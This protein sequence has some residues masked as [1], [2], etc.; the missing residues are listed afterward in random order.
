MGRGD[1]EE[2][3]G[4]RRSRWLGLP[5]QDGEEVV[6]LASPSKSANL[7]KYLYTLGLYGFWRRRDRAVVTDRRVLIGRGIFSRDE[8]SIP[9]SKITGARFVRKGVNSYAQLSIDD[10]GRRRTEQ[11]G[12]MSS[13]AARQFVAEVLAR[14]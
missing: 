2:S 9:M 12:P 5:L 3:G 4:G 14:L 6:L 8:H 1:K 13:R 7:H 10:R 11:V